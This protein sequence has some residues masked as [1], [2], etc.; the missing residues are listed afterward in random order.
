MQRLE[1]SGTRTRT[2]TSTTLSPRRRARRRSSSRA[3]LRPRDHGSGRRGRRRGT[4]STPGLA[5]ELTLPGGS[6]FL[7]MHAAISKFEVTVPSDR[8]P[9]WRSVRRQRGPERLD[10]HGDSPLL[11][12]LRTRSKDRVRAAGSKVAQAQ[13]QRIRADRVGRGHAAPRYALCH[14]CQQG[15]GMRSNASGRGADPTACDADGPAPLEVNATMVE[16][17]R[18]KLRAEIERATAKRAHSLGGA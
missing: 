3:R 2:A 14:E 4:A 7:P 17:D 9:P 16:P 13:R 6:S 11:L 12:A 5:R 8:S 10:A 1:M 18:C 15:D